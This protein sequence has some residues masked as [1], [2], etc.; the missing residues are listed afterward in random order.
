MCQG[1]EGFLVAL[2]SALN[3]KLIAERDLDLLARRLP[4]RFSAPV[5]F[6]C[7]VAQS[8][9]ESLA[10]WRLLQSGIVARPQVRIPTV[11]RVD[12]LIGNSLIVELDGREFHEFDEDRRRDANAAAL[13]YVTHRYSYRQVLEEWPFVRSAIEAHMRLGLHLLHS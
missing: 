4:A 13:S 7:V 3:K 6:A 11:G 8:G 12:L 5:S 1:V 10:R 2:E 9:I